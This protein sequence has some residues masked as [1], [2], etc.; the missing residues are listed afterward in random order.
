M[1]ISAKK[2]WIVT[3]GLVGTENQ[4]LGVAEALARQLPDSVTIPFRIKLRE[5][6][7]TL[8][9][10]LG[11]EQWWSFDPLLEPPWP[12]IL[13]TSGR[14]AIASARFIKKDQRRQ[15]IRPAYTRPAD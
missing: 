12:D 5:P 10:W 6:W 1:T 14:K 4:C 7:K 15:N 9:P 11:L 2:I 13:I 3:E 8:S